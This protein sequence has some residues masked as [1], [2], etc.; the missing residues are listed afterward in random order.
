LF[1]LALKLD[2]VP[3]NCLWPC[4]HTLVVWGHCPKERKRKN[5]LS[6]LCLFWNKKRLIVWNFYHA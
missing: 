4:V 6:A 3:Y 5:L 1:S 2:C